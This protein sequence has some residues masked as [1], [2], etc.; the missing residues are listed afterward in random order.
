MDGGTRGIGGEVGDGAEVERR[1]SNLGD[2]R[3]G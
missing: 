3:A 1:R 2:E